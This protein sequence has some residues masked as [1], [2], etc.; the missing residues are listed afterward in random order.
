[1]P[2][3]DTL[4]KLAAL[5]GLLSSYAG[6]AGGYLAC[7]N[8]FGPSRGLRLATQPA[9]ARAIRLVFKLRRFGEIGPRL[10]KRVL[11]G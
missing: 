3:T 7:R 10:P 1:M 2:I 4:P 9:I 8:V 5:F 6:L 11:V